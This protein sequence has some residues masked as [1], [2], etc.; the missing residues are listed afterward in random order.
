[1]NYSLILAKKG[2]GGWLWVDPASGKERGVCTVGEA[3]GKLG[4]SRRQVY[5]HIASGTLESHGKVFGEWLLD[6]AAV[7]RL[8]SSPSSAQPVPARMS[9]LFSEYD[10][11]RLNAGRDRTTVVTR[12]LD[13]G[14]RDEVRW[15]LRRLPLRAVKDCLIQDGAR[16][17]S[18]RALRLWSLYF[19]V[20]PKPLPEWRARGNPWSA[21]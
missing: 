4:L 11:S 6:R 17:M 14:T 3:C 2:S 8:A 15:L 16:L 12:I 18:D 7:E 13:R 10:I 5:R 20:T 19:G 1:M 21:R 9:V